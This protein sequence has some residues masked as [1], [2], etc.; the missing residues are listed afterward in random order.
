RPRSPDVR[1]HGKSSDRPASIVALAPAT[2][3][4]KMGLMGASCSRGRRVD[5]CAAWRAAALHQE[6]VKRF[7]P[8]E[9][10]KEALIAATA[11]PQQGIGVVVTELGENVSDAA[12]ADDV[13]RHYTNAL[14]KI[15]TTGL[16]CQISVKLTQLG[17][18][19]DADRCY[20]NVCTLTARAREHG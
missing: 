14:A 13:T 17:L 16:D 18:D 10:L 7:M 6:A 3:S 4:R 15:G 20:D 5:G 8:G 19:V 2:L 11:L 12:Q 9:T 1:T